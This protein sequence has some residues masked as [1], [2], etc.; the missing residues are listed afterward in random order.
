MQLSTC[1]LGRIQP[2][3][4]MLATTV[5]LF[6]SPA[7][8]SRCLPLGTGHVLAPHAAGRGGGCHRH[9]VLRIREPGRCTAGK[10]HGAPAEACMGHAWGREGIGSLAWGAE[11]G[12]RSCGEQAMLRFGPLSPALLPLPA[13]LQGLPAGG[14]VEFEVELL[15]FDR[16]A[17][18]H[19]LPGPA[20]LERGQK[21]KEQGNTLYKQVRVL[22]A[23]RWPAH[24][25]R[26]MRV[27]N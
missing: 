13:S 7:R 6:S 8:P 12:L 1:D 26:N 16:E 25:P 20:K 15:G 17:N 11:H 21:L 19:A 9:L 2:E 22:G 24:V 27:G 3:H 14:R 23:C 5:S 10:Q 18:E 4:S